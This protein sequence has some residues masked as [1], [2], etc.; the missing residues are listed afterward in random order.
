[1]ESSRTYRKWATLPDLGS[2]IDVEK[3]SDIDSVAAL[4]NKCFYVAG[5]SNSTSGVH[6][7]LSG[8]VERKTP[9]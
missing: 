5:T 8:Y 3:Q 2:R 1:M 9:L 7:S 4:S 6:P